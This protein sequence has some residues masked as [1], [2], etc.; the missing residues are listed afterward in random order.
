MTNALPLAAV[1]SGGGGIPS[2]LT[3]LLVVAGVGYVLWSRTQ[4]RPLKARRLVVLPLLFIVLGVSDLS[5]SSAPHLTSTAIAFLFASCVISIVLGAAR[6]ATIELYPKDGEL[7]QRYRS[8]TVVLWIALIA[9]K[10]VL[11]VVAHGTGSAAGAGTDSLLLA[12]GLSLLAEA[13]VIAPRALSTGVPF[14][15]SQARHDTRPAPGVQPRD[16]PA[17]QSRLSAAPA[18]ATNRPWQSPTLQDATERS[19]QPS[20]PRPEQPAS[21]TSAVQ[22]LGDAL[23]RHHENHRQRHHDRRARRQRY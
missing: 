2:P 7:W 19:R 15:T 23:I 1:Q 16:R 13:A 10:I 9:A 20:D 22:G 14:A 11:A 8:S 6:G 17:A 4:G 12:L 5:S 3:I 18:Q 21:E